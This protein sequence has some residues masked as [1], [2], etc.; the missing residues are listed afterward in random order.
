MD[1]FE[2]V[3]A[4]VASGAF[5]GS[6]KKAEKRYKLFVEDTLRKVVLGR[7]EHQLVS[8]GFCAKNPT[9]RLCLAAGKMH[10]NE[11]WL[12]A[13]FE[14]RAGFFLVQNTFGGS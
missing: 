4:A 6:N 10:R 7:L 5:D 2:T 13:H 9:I 12:Q 8:G 1:A 3:V 14:K 11:S